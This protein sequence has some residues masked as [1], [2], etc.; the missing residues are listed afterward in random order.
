MG[1]ALLVI[2]ILL[3]PVLRAQ[4]VDGPVN[5]V[6]PDDST[7]AAE[8]LARLPQLLAGNNVP[9]A[10]RALQRL[11]DEEGDRVIASA[12]EPDLFTS[13][14]TRVHAALLDAPDLLAR[15]RELETPAARAL[16]DADPARVE[17][18]RLLT[19]EGFEACLR[20]AQTE[21]DAAHFES[22]R[23]LLEQLGGHPDFTGAA[24]REAARLMRDVSAY[25]PRE[26]IIALARAWAER[27]GD[28][29]VP[30]ARVAW[31][32]GEPRESGVFSPALDLDVRELVARPLHSVRLSGGSAPSVDRRGLSTEGPMGLTDV[33][34]IRGDEVFVGD[35]LSF[36][37]WDRYTLTPRWRVRPES[38]PPPRDLS[39]LNRD[40]GLWGELALVR[41][42][43]VSGDLLFGATGRNSLSGQLGDP[44]MHALRHATGEFVWSWSPMALG[45]EYH[46][47]VPTGLPLVHEDTLVFSI[48]KQMHDE[49]VWALRL[50]G[51]EAPTGRVRWARAISAVGSLPYDPRTG[52]FRASVPALHEGIIYRAEAMGVIVAIEAA[53]GRVRWLRRAPGTGLAP[54]DSLPPTALSGPVVWRDSIFVITNDASRILEINRA[55]GAI[56]AERASANMGWPRY[57]LLVGE[58]LV[59]VGSRYASAVP[60]SEFESA[61]VSVSDAY[62]GTSVTGRALV[63]PG[64]LVLPTVD[65]FLRFDV[66]HETGG[67]IAGTHVDLDSSGVL[68][69]VEGQILALDGERL[70][71]YLVWPVAE[72]V[73]L[74]RMRARPDDAEPA[75]VF[76]EL[77]A[78][79]GHAERIGEAARAAADILRTAAEPDARL[80]DRLVQSLARMLDRS[81]RDDAPERALLPAPVAADLIDVLSGLAASPEERAAALLIEGREHERRARP[82]DALGAY[83][84]VLASPELCEAPWSGPDMSTRAELEAARRVRFVV[85][86]A[87]GSYEPFEREADA[88]PH[89]ANAAEFAARARQYPAAREAPAWWLSAAEAYRGEGNLEEAMRSL[90]AG[91][92]TLRAF[93]RRG[94]SPAGE[95]AGL[96]VRLLAS[97]GRLNEASRVLAEHRELAPGLPLTAQGEP[98]DADGLVRDLAELE[99]SRLRRPALAHELGPGHALDG[100]H[101]AIRPPPLGAPA[102]VLLSRVEDGGALTLARYDAPPGAG[103]RAAWTR[104]LSPGSQVL[105]CDEGLVLVGESA[106]GS[107]RLRRLAPATGE[108]LWET[109]ALESLVEALPGAARVGP[110]TVETTMDG[111]VPER[112][113]LVAHDER[114]VALVQRS[115]LA[116]GVDLASGRVLWSAD[117][118]LD[119][120]HDAAAGAGVLAAGGRGAAQSGELVVVDL[121]TGEGRFRISSREGVLPGPVRWV[122]LGERGEV[123]AGADEGVLCASAHEARVIWTR[124]DDAL[125]A[126]MDA[127][128]V[129]DALVILDAQRRLRLGRAASGLFELDPLPQRALLASTTR[130]DLVPTQDGFA[131]LTGSGIGLFSRQGELVG[132]DALGADNTLLPPVPIDG[133]FLAL[134]RAET[135]GEETHLLRFDESARL[136]PPALKV[137]LAGEAT[138]LVVLDGALLLETEGGVAVLPDVSGR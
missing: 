61:R 2:L 81:Q 111:R 63:T 54:P 1:R 5:P 76:A 133:G 103:L 131:V 48:E 136:V 126:T 14:R 79:A 84:R 15:Y 29:W 90:R 102:W 95:L 17:R 88:S 9:E 10:A 106:A 96:L 27:A 39:Q 24:A 134:R 70:H 82:G 108:L 6:F 65:G 16:L 62:E 31:P 128:I 101:F 53:S 46:A 42:I 91:L 25:L 118:R 45:P 129:G 138:N 109:P 43:T 110:S 44:R 112:Q 32:A 72:G 56:R 92:D 124:S 114:T 28:P 34:L 13:V 120:V 105:A 51:L 55:D 74:A 97:E 98:I 83:Q 3:A 73:L 58:T 80:H 119:R 23:L 38:P 132:A 93:D 135:A 59:G 117:L 19:P 22:A 21:L 35:G 57:L 40:R 75:I 116:V 113:F 71:S 37:A 8:T 47:F 94:E 127:W 86:N 64:G 89:P 123:I 66:P 115:G 100:W 67:H 49:R 11:L 33:P 30:A 87:P 85:M 18:T 125:R 78:Q 121:R 69:S 107:S 4:P 122:R 60:A 7:L 52:D 68:V 36:A 137:R 130:V 99:A 12:R 20:L 41:G 104:P 77:A 50:V 26:E